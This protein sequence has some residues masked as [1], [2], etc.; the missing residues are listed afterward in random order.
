M[1]TE[2]FSLDRAANTV[3]MGHPGQGELSFGDPATF[4]VT[5]DLEFD[6]SQPAGA[7]ISYRA[8]AGEMTFLNLTPEYGKLKVAAFTG[9]EPGGPR[10][11]EG[12][13]HMLI[14]PDSNAAELFENI[15]KLGLLQHWG[16]VHGRILPE[17]RFLARQLNLQLRE[18]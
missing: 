8:K 16:A 13:S 2:F 3:L 14:Q 17:L 11:M 5:R 15:V 7:W 6:P 4:M 9:R 18:L 1:F 10:I 12:Y